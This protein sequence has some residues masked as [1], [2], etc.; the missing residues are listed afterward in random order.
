MRPSTPPSGPGCSCR[1]DQQ[2]TF[3]H[4]LVRSEL[5]ASLGPASRTTR[6][7]A[8]AEAIRSRAGDDEA[9]VLDALAHHYSEAAADGDPRDAVRYA[10]AAGHQAIE[11]LAHH[12]GVSRFELGLLALARSGADDPRL[13]LD[14]L[15]DLA[16]AWRR[17][18]QLSECGRAGA[19]AL[20]L[21]LAVGEARDQ[22]ARR[23][24]RGPPRPGRPRRPRPWRGWS[25]P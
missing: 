1:R 2:L 21:A 7:R 17:T 4:D 10:S 14:L 9:R 11:R 20:P 24:R 16:E 22:A 13:E 12:T 3:R 15:L 6:H 19:R 8:I 5:A 25:T 18:G 23:G